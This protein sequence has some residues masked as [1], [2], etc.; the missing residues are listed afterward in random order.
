MLTL[1]AFHVIILQNNEGPGPKQKLLTCLRYKCT[2]A[3]MRTFTCNL[4]RLLPMKNKWLKF[5]D[6]DLFKRCY[7]MLTKPVKT[8]IA[9]I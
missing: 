9:P 4:A 3:I 8:T 2:W 6:C 5:S 7:M 1:E